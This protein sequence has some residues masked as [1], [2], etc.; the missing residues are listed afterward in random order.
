MLPVS[1][2]DARVRPTLAL[3]M[4]H[5]NEDMIFSNYRELVKPKDAER[6]WNIR[7]ATTEKVVQLVAPA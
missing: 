6:Y 5:T 1:R 2:K 3:E 7:P 4:G